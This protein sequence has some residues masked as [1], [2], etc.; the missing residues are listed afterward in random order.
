MILHQNTITKLPNDS[1][2][3]KKQIKTMS[4]KHAYWWYLKRFGTVENFLKTMS[5]KH[6][7]GQNLKR[8]AIAENILKIMSLKHAF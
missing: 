7:F 2:L 8:F 3:Q 5:F 6:A 4:L 1:E